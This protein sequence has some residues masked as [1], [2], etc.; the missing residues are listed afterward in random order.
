MGG[1]S[2]TIVLHDQTNKANKINLKPAMIAPI[3]K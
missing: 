2:I 1:L 3:P